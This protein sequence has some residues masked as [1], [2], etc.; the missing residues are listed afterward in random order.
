MV[1]AL[2]DLGAQL[3]NRYDGTESRSSEW[4]RRNREAGRQF[5]DHQL[6]ISDFYTS[7]LRATEAR[8]DV[9]LIEPDELVAAFPEHIRNSRHPFSLRATLADRGTQYEIGIIPDFAFGLRFSDGSRRCFLVEIDRGTMPVSRSDL[10]QTSFKRKMYAYL[11]AYAAK[12]HESRFGWKAFGVLTVT[13]DDQR[14][15]SMR[16]ALHQLNASN[17][18]GASLFLFAAREGLKASDPLAYSWHDGNGNTVR[19]M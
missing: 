4:T 19:L 6:Q 16:E 3:L 12:Q 14:M 17:G 2:S 11:T 7:V 8:A 13:T 1:Y 15:R 9:E 5:V 10:R 18:S